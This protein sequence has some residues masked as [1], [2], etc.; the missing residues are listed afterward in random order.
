MEI[1]PQ[2]LT[3][4]KMA[5][6][7]GSA[8]D[9]DR[10]VGDNKALCEYLAA[11]LSE[12]EDEIIKLLC[13]VLVDRTD[14]IGTLQ[15]IFEAP[16]SSC[17]WLVVTNERLIYTGIVSRPQMH[18]WGGV[19]NWDQAPDSQQFNLEEIR[20]AEVNESKAGIG[21]DVQ[22]IDGERLVANADANFENQL[23]NI[24]DYVSQH[25]VG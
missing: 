6:P 9:L 20:S 22:T 10:V 14:R 24:A 5:Y 11:A 2:I 15:R 21:L 17:G 18:S 23:R 3:A 8:T 25:I 13:P 12:S 19:S 7:A 16:I 4:L 1:D